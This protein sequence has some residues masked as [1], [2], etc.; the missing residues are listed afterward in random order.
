MWENKRLSSHYGLFS[1][2]PN[3]FILWTSTKLCIAIKQVAS[4]YSHLTQYVFIIAQ[5]LWTRDSL[6]GKFCFDP[7]FS[8]CHW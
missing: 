8:D 5:S 4:T 3:D 1:M 2:K 6:V 7:S